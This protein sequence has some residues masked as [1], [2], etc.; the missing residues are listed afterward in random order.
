[1]KR[2]ILVLTVWAAFSPIV[3]AQETDQPFL[4]YHPYDFRLAPGMSVHPNSFLLVGSGEYRLDRFFALGLLLQAGLGH[5]SWVTPT[6]GGRFIAPIYALKRVEFSLQ[7]GIGWTYRSDG[8]L[9]FTNFV[10]E[11]SPN[12]DVYILPYLTVGVGYILN[13]VSEDTVAFMNSVYASV[14]Y[15]F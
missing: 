13:V 8:T 5:Q 9:N 1:M 4:T 3:H 6:V 2:L 10:Y 7:S 12:V 15:R 11:I 14:G